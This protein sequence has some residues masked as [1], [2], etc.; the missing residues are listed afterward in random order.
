MSE[1]V[2]HGLGEVVAGN[3][4]RWRAG[5]GLDQQALADR[6][7]K[8]GWT[9]DR[10]TV[11]RI[12]KGTRKV[13]VDDLGLLA[14]ALNVPLPLLILPAHEARP[15]AL[16][17][18]GKTSALHP[19]MLWEWMLGNEPLPGR[20]ESSGDEWRSGAEPLW[21]YERVRVAQLQ[22]RRLDLE[23]VETSG[24]DYVTALQELVDAVSD[25]NTVGLPA[26]DLVADGYRQHIEALDL[27]PSPRG[28][29]YRTVA[30]LDASREEH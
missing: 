17:S 24:S 11:V 16:T 18:A 5:R 6:L 4:R 3:V 20:I 9:V 22:L 25:M 19:W 23:R 2:A 29:R 26:D 27:A 28:R 12:E 10:T 7:G 1:K 8:L 30:E 21:V 14:V 13:T 15:V